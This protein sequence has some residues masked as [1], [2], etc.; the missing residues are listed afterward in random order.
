MAVFR[1][2]ENKRPLVRAANTGI[3]AFIDANGRIVLQGGL[4]TEEVLK[5]SVNI[6]ESPSTFYT[7]FGD[8][9]AFL[10]IALSS[11]KLLAIFLYRRTPRP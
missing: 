8:L 11:I 4:F 2:V 1:A 10:L 3:S 9:F 5:A 7:R 6:T